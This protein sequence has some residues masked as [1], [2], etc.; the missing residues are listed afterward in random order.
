MNLT[1]ARR[2]LAA[3]QT[4]TTDLGLLALRLWLAQEFLQAGWTKVSAGGS[5]PEWFAGLPFPA[6]IA[7]LPVDVNWVAAGMGELVLGA[8]LLIGLWPRLAALGLL[9]ITWVAVVTVHFDLGWAGW[10]QIEAEDGL[11]FKLP[12]MMAVMLLAIATQG[13]GRYALGSVWTRRA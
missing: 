13:G 4:A 12:L 10:N 9:F 7:W 1:M 2:T 5:A 8:A 11:G 6:V 3:L